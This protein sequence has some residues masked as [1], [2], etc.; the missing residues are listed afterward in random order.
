MISL[1][2]GK[3]RIGQAMLAAIEAEVL[4]LLVQHTVQAAMAGELGARELAEVSH[5]AGRSCR[6]TIESF[7]ILP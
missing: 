2:D 1:L 6:G 7:S 3:A 5:G 4:A